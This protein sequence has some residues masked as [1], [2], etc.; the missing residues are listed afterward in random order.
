MCV[1]MVN[2]FDFD[3]KSKA[4]RKDLRNYLNFYK[5]LNYFDE[6]GKW[7]DM[8][9]FLQIEF[10]VS[11]IFKLLSVEKKEKE[12]SKVLKRTINGNKG[13]VSKNAKK[14]SPLERA[15]AKLVEE[16]TKKDEA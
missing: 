5:I 4:R 1:C 12:Y 11:Y 10:H 16:E 14:I 15:L 8:K 9:I 7:K 6:V 13:T 2:V 3:K